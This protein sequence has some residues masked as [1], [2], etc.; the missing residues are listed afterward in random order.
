MNIFRPFFRPPSR[1]LLFH[2]HF[3]HFGFCTQ[4]CCFCT[5]RFCWLAFLFAW[6]ST[7]T[8]SWF[9][10]VLVSWYPYSSL[11]TGGPSFG[12]WA[13]VCGLLGGPPETGSTGSTGQRQPGAVEHVPT[14]EAEHAVAQLSNAERYGSK[15]LQGGD[16][17]RRR[18]VFCCS[19]GPPAIG[20]LSHPFFGWE[21]SSAEIDYTWRFILHE[22]PGSSR[23]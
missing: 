18:F 22:F 9:T 1:T 21:G 11:S 23:L 8:G 14:G 10:V 20:A 16:F 17:G 19:L 2:L 3:T 12:F 15:L 13:R 4:P 5:L 6:G 7:K